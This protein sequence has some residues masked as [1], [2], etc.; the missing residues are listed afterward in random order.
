[1]KILQ[2]R[3]FYSAPKVDSSNVIINESM[4]KLMGTAGHIG[5]I[6]TDGG[7]GRY[8]IVGIIRDFLYNDMYADPGPLMLFCN[9]ENTG[10]L[11]IRFRA[12]DGIGQT[13]EKIAGIIRQFNPGYPVDYR[14]LDEDFAQM[15]KLESLLGQLAGLFAV[16]A[17]VLSCLGLM[18]LTAYTVERST[19]EVAIR[20]VLGA[21]AARI[22]EML[23]RQFIRPVLISYIIAFP[24]AWWI[25]NNWLGEYHYHIQINWLVFAAAG[26]LL[27]LITMISVLAQT[28]KAAVANPVTKLRSE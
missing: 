6:I 16:L 15:F 22:A 5:G 18:G 25:M 13:T 8:Q 3:D 23:S 4:A 7:G 1:M 12:S 17:I 19:R 28:I 24:I 10:Y 11:N 21:S 20:K 27:L 9:P 14:F 26:L 2:G